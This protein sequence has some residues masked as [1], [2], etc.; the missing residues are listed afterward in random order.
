MWPKLPASNYKQRTSAPKLWMRWR[1]GGRNTEQPLRHLYGVPLLSKCFPEMIESLT[2]RPNVVKGSRLLY[3]KPDHWPSA[4]VVLDTRIILTR[5]AA[6]TCSCPIRL[7]GVAVANN[8]CFGLSLTADK[9]KNLNN[10]WRRTN[11]SL[12]SVFFCEYFHFERQSILRWKSSM[13]RCRA[14]SLTT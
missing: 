9:N 8:L 6:N 3:M 13:A 11:A 10:V 2:G 4:C 12:M 5:D 1:E 7:K 14:S